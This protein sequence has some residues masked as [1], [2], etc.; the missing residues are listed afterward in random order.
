[1]G[2]QPT[3]KTIIERG[4]RAI[5]KYRVVIDYTNTFR[6]GTTFPAN[7]IESSLEASDY[8][9]GYSPEGIVMD[10]LHRD[11]SLGRFMFNGFWMVRC[12]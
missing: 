1:M 5:N 6:P 8:V 4:Y 9:P 11:T 3:D 10:K 12:E 2:N 7:D